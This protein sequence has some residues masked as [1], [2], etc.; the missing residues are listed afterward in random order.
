M[1][2]PFTEFVADLCEHLMSS[3]IK[4]ISMGIQFDTINSRAL[5]P[6]YFLFALLKQM[7]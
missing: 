1:P 2:E 7:I 6:M 5:L 3:L 4:D